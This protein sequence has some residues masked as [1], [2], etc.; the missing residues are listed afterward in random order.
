MWL[1]LT[2]PYNQGPILY[3]T[4]HIISV[5]GMRDN[6]TALV[7]AIDASGE[8]TRWAVEQSTAEIWDAIRFGATCVNLHDAEEDVLDLACATQDN[9]ASTL[10]TPWFDSKLE[11]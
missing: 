10:V 11:E 4:D 8:Q 7:L 2:R 3:N 1:K 5:Q 9:P 6:H